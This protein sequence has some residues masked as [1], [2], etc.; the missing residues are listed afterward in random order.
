MDIASADQLSKL[1]RKWYP[2]LVV[3]VQCSPTH[4]ALAGQITASWNEESSVAKH[5]LL[6]S[7]VVVVA[8]GARAS[9]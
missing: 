7:A 8:L 2:K 4:M 9:V 1:C 6:I 3:P 5:N